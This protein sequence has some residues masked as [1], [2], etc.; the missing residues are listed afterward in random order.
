MPHFFSCLL[1]VKYLLLPFS[2][3]NTRLESSY[4]TKLWGSVYKRKGEINYIL[5]LKLPNIWKGTWGFWNPIVKHCFYFDALLS[6]FYFN[7]ISKICL[8]FSQ[9]SLNLSIFCGMLNCNKD[10]NINKNHT[11]NKIDKML[12]GVFLNLHEK[13]SQLC[14][15]NSWNDMVNIHIVGTIFP[16]NFIL[17]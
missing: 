10:R 1:T 9:Q 8:W 11:L 7:S 2:L 17:C 6:S 4:G 14:S 15:H 16:N 13:N 5:G 12:P 3:L